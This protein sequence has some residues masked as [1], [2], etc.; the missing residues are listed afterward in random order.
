[1]RR[2]LVYS[3]LGWLVPALVALAAVPALT[4]A[5]GPERFGLLALAWGAVAAFGQFDLG[6]GRATTFLV[7]SGQHRR[8]AIVAGAGAWVW[9]IFG[10]LAVVAFAAAPW[11]AA[12]VLDVPAALRAETVGVVRL[13]AV[14]V[15]VAIHGIV[16]RGALEGEARWG[17]VNL[18]RAPMGLLTWGGPLLVAPF[19]HDVRALVAVIVSARV[20]Y[21]LAQWGAL[22]WAWRAPAM[23]ILVDAGGWMTVS[24]VVAPVLSL[25]DRAAV[26]ALVPIAAVGWY[27]GTGEAATK[28]WIVGTVLQP[29]LFQ[30]MTA[31]QAAGAS[32]RPLMRRGTG[33]TLAWTVVP[34]VVLVVWAAP[35]LEWWLS[36]SYVPAAAP[37]FR[38]LVVAVVVNNLALVPYAALHAAGAARAVAMVHVAQLPLYVPALWW[39]TATYGAAGAAVAWSV[40]IG[41]DAA[42][43]W[44]LAARRVR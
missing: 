27:V 29:V 21:W 10:P 19:T 2:G 23:R 32:L 44:V 26:S 1:V 14:A 17:L 6:L 35:I 11:L 15:P 16:L 30:A 34:A 25:V 43:L 37:A 4:R 18:L 38:W 31:Q 3:G 33:I 41:L 40:R 20:L 7:A 28:L 5:L 22:G 12:S 36:T 24:G 42:A 8:D 39:A 9:L 13:L